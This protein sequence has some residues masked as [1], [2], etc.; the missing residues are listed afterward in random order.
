MDL[1]TF[2]DLS[3]PA[4]QDAIHAA[5]DLG[6]DTTTTVVYTDPDGT[7]G[8]VILKEASGQGLFSGIGLESTFESGKFYVTGPDGATVKAIDPEKFTRG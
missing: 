1:L 7:T 6:P 2:R 8:T 5:V 3:S 4:G